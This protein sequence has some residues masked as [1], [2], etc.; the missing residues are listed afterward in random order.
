VLIEIL[1]YEFLR[2]WCFVKP[3]VAGLAEDTQ[4]RLRSFWTS[5]PVAEL[6]TQAP[7]PHRDWHEFI[8]CLNA[9]RQGPPRGDVATPSELESHERSD[10]AWWRTAEESERLA[11]EDPI[12]GSIA[13]LCCLARWEGELGPRLFSEFR[14]PTHWG[15][16]PGWRHYP[17]IAARNLLLADAIWTARRLARIARESIEGSEAYI[18]TRVNGLRGGWRAQ[19]GGEAWWQAGT[20]YGS[21]LREV[22][23]RHAAAVSE[24]VWD[25]HDSCS[26][27]TASFR[28]EIGALFWS[29]GD[30]PRAQLLRE[31]EAT[32][33]REAVAGLIHRSL[34]MI[35]NDPCVQ[36]TW[37]RLKDRPPFSLREHPH[38]F[39]TINAIWP[40][41]GGRDQ[42]V[43]RAYADAIV[44]HFRHQP[45]PDAPGRLIHAYRQNR[46]P[47]T[48][49]ALVRL[50]SL[51]TVLDPDAA[52]GWSGM[53]P[54]LRWVTLAERS[55]EIVEARDRQHLRDSYD[56]VLDIPFYYLEHEG[57]AAVERAIALTER[58]RLAGMWFWR[59]VVAPVMEDKV[60][61]RWHKALRRRSQRARLN[62]ERMHRLAQRWLPPAKIT[63]P[64]M[65]PETR[66]LMAE[67]G[68]LIEAVRGAR[69]SR[70]RPL[71]PSGYL[72]VDRSITVADFE[73]PA[74]GPGD[75][76]AELA[77]RLDAV[78][79]RIVELAPEQAAAR[80][81]APVGVDEFAAALAPWQM[82]E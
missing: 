6:P 32:P 44:A 74:S 33:S 40:S 73:P 78:A 31:T 67:E 60:T 5:A 38:V 54:A 46:Q 21:L 50:D 63:H 4:Q 18:A 75:E 17:L 29:L 34:E 19:T 49:E 82:L 47:L 2:D 28:A 71:L 12:A 1:S 14:L 56:R 16:A 69:F 61:P 57:Y 13:A 53:P 64:C 22:D 48:P 39:T 27:G 70:L 58:H 66:A 77:E 79:E 43:S 68:E 76:V 23:A 45:D 9:L 55:C 80:L 11:A 20:A 10:K 52:T 36:F 30:V 62:W 15:L 51:L 59:R 65:D 7:L 81:V 42:P 25:L 72:R 41:H 24:F 3:I 35:P 8:E 37:L 26:S